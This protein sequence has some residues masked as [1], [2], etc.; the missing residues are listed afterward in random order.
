MEW[1]QSI[2]IWIGALPAIVKAISFSTFLGFGVKAIKVMRSKKQAGQQRPGAKPDPLIEG[3]LR[4]YGEMRESISMAKSIEIDAGIR[5]RES[6][7]KAAKELMKLDSALSIERALMLVDRLDQ[8]LSSTPRSLGAAR[9]DN[10]LPYII[11]TTKRA[12][13]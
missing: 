3:S 1:L 2:Y 12:A 11:T 6:K 7:L 10:E 13:E 5:D 9:V 4:G 8:S